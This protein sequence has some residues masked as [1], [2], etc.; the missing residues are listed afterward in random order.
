M[1]IDKEWHDS[2]KISHHKVRY[3]AFKSLHIFDENTDN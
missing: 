2:T 1:F 3:N